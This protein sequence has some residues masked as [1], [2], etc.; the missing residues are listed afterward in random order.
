MIG[1][2]FASDRSTFPTD[3]ESHLLNSALLNQLGP[4]LVQSYLDHF[5]A[6]MPLV[7]LR[8]F[9]TLWNNAGMDMARLAPTTRTL[10][11]M[12]QAVGATFTALPQ[13]AGQGCPA[14]T[15]L[16][17]GC[18]YAQ[19]GRRRATMCRAY[20]E[21]ALQMMDEHGIT[22]I[23][24]SESIVIHWLALELLECT[25]TFFTDVRLAD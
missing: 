4:S 6:T 20:A 10:A 9:C 5:H 7:N 23:V 15:Q 17:D 21:R 2:D 22:K 3:T 24:S 1:S 11:M 19:Y 18:D 16:I 13:I 8:H 25:P 12:M 14:P